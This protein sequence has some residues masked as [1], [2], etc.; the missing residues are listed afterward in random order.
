MNNARL[1][2]ISE[3]LEQSGCT[4]LN[5]EC[6][7]VFYRD[8]DGKIHGRTDFPFLLEKEKVTVRK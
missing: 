8:T 7:M 3:Q 2:A 1:E 6:G 4:L 5:V